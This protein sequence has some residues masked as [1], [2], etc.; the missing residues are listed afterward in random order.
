MKHASKSQWEGFISTLHAR[1]RAAAANDLEIGRTTFTD[2]TGQ[3]WRA[4]MDWRS[5]KGAGELVYKSHAM[6]P[7]GRGAL[8][9][10]PFE[11]EAAS[12]NGEG[13][14]RA[15]FGETFVRSPAP[16]ATPL[17]RHASSSEKKGEGL[18]RLIFGGDAA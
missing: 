12:G 7:N 18:A 13:L 8:V 10:V 16:S 9:A 3:T 11:E 6:V 14:A 2:G 17:E 5:T 4:P 1:G 15:I